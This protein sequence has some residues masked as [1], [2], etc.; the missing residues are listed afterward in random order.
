MS[1]R[2]D[3]NE[4]VLVRGITTNLLSPKSLE[5]YE[6][7]LCSGIEALNLRYYD[8]YDW[9]DEWDSGNH[10]NTLPIAVEINIMFEAKDDGGVDYNNEWER[11]ISCSFTLPCA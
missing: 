9:L 8:G 11:S 2:E 6:D 7:I 1:T 10:D 5:P 4:T 3:T